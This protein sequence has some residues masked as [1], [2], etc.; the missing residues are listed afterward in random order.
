MRLT[1]SIAG[2][3]AG[4]AL[5]IGAAVAVAPA[6]HAAPTHAGKGGVRINESCGGPHGCWIDWH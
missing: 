3:L 1:R 5:S 4:L 6:A 2:V